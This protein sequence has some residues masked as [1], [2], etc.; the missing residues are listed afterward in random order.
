[1]ADEEQACMQAVQLALSSVLP[2]TLKTAIEL[3]LLD[4]LV[5][6]GGKLLTPVEVAEMLPS[7]D[8]PDAPSMVDRMLRVLASHNV[9][10]CVVEEGKDG[11]LSRRYGAAPVC[12]WLTPNEDGVSMAPWALSAQD[13]VFMETW[14]YMKDAVLTGGSPFHK[15]YGMT[16]FEYAGTDIR[17]NR[18]FN[19]AMKHQSVI[20][21]N[22]LLELY[23]GFDGVGTL[24]DVGGGVGATINAIISKY[25]SIKGINFDLPH[26]ISE[27]T[28]CFPGVHVQHVGGNML[29]K[30]PSGDAILMKW[31]L[32]CFSDQEC[33]RLL[34]NCYDALPAHGKL[35]SVECLLPVIPEATPSAQ[36][37]TQIDMSLLAYSDGGKERYH[38]ELEELAKAAGFA[39]VKSTTYI[40]ANFW[41]MEYTKT[42]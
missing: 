24:V 21:T 2:M 41:A 27:A 20:I 30:V 37:M 32:N 12:K 23:S 4:T 16:W 31:I 5:G 7:K 39:G 33:A 14:C 38:G 3:G 15:A 34:K 19:E 8:N 40:Y 11:S 22:K 42:K 35:I 18:L 10:S 29:D 26:V 28:P 1:M 9:V 13:R 17:F 36:G 6:A 25:P